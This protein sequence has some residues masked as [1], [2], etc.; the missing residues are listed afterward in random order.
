MFA[1]RHITGVAV[2][3][4]ILA[5][6]S[7]TRLNDVTRSTGDLNVTEV[8]VS[9]DNMEPVSGRSF[10]RSKAQFQQEL[11]VAVWDVLRASSNPEGTPATVMLDVKNMS[12]SNIAMRTLGQL[13][14]I[15]ADLT[16]T[17][18][19]GVIVPR[20][21]VVGESDGIRLAGTFGA[22]TVP[23]LDKDYSQTVYGFA[24]TIEDLLFDKQ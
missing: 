7:T 17:S 2:S 24:Y 4:A 5:G 14:S 1:H 3:A 18:E 15:T 23:G 8:I 21:T 9:L 11:R 13:S 10:N 19:A 12:L 6:C 16:V 22:V 20:Q